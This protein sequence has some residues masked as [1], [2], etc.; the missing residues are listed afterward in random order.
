MGEET[1]NAWVL[2]IPTNQ[3]SV[4]MFYL[5][6]SR[7]GYVSSL[8]W[9]L[10]LKHCMTHLSLLE[11]KLFQKLKLFLLLEY[12]LPCAQLNLLKYYYC[13]VWCS[14]WFTYLVLCIPQFGNLCSVR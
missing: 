12:F 5:K 10:S 4:V 7:Y 6:P 8:N 9:V 1:L 11:M 2:G 13:S 14:R 3:T